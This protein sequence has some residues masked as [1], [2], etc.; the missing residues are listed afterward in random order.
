V[1]VMGMVHGG[2][3]GEGG[4]DFGC[5]FPERYRRQLRGFRCVSLM[6]TGH[7]FNRRTRSS[8]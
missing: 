1:V 8:P 5:G 2:D 7:T 4:E 3:E 6:P